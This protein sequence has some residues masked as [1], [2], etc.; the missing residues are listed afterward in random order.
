MNLYVVCSG[1]EV[2]CDGLVQQLSESRDVTK[3]M[4]DVLQSSR[5]TGAAEV[6]RSAQP[7]EGMSMVWVASCTEH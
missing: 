3:T 7:G 4:A 6:H 5:G 2:I 1:L